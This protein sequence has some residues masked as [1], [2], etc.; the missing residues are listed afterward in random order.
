MSVLVKLFIFI[1]Q[2]LPVA[3]AFLLLLTPDCKL[4]FRFWGNVCRSL[5]FFCAI[6]SGK[7]QE[8]ILHVM[9]VRVRGGACARCILYDNTV[10]LFDFLFAAYFCVSGLALPSIGLFGSS[11]ISNGKPKW[12]WPSFFP[13]NSK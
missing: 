3:Y 11:C 8:C 4:H 10:V 5:L 9:C 7:K 2:N 1:Y 6:S 12:G 13:F